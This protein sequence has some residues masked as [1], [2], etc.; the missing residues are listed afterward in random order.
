MILR[1]YGNSALTPFL[2]TG[3]VLWDL[4][5]HWIVHNFIRP[6]FTAKKVL[7]VALGIIEKGLTWNEL[8]AIQRVA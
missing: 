6:H 7:A 8:F 5:L 1:G 4:D 3:S 2:G